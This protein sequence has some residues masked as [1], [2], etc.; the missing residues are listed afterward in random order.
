M[1][2]AQ[3]TKK[4]IVASPVAIVDNASFTTNV[5][6]TKGW[7]YC[8]IDCI[9]GATDIALTALKVQEA[10]ATSSATALTS[11]ADV[12]GLVFGTSADIAGTTSTLPSATN[13]DKVFTFEVDCKTRMRYLDVTATMGDG[14]TGGFMAILATLYRGENPGTTASARGCQQILRV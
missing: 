11:G 10:E 1:N 2:A 6:D 14:A 7:D 5:I 4:V 12:T 13:D 9:L 3:W 8:V